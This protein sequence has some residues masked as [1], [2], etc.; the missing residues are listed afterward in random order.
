MK[1]KKKKEKKKWSWDNLDVVDPFDAL[2]ILGWMVR[3]LIG[4]F[5]LIIKI[6]Q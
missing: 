3:G 4:L 5:R 6:F 2:T 1:I